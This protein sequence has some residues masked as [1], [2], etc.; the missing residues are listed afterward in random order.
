[1]TTLPTNY[2]DKKRENQIQDSWERKTY[3]IEKVYELIDELENVTE[4]ITQICAEKNNNL[5]NEHLG[6]NNDVIE[7]YT[8]AKTWSL[9]NKLCPKNTAEAPAAKK[10]DKGNFVTE[11]EALENLYLEAYKKRLQPNPIAEEFTV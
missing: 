10:N 6:R 2:I 3:D 5:V 8:Q 1:M 4:K 9:K 7:G 11:R